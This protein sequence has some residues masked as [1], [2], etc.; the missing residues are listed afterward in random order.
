MFTAISKAIEPAPLPREVITSKRIL[1]SAT[2]MPML[3]RPY[4]GYMY[5]LPVR[6]A[7]TVR[8]LP[9]GENIGLTGW[10]NGFAISA[11]DLQNVPVGTYTIV[12]V[13]VNDVPAG[14]VTPTTF[15]V[16]AGANPDTWIS[17]PVPPQ[18]IPPLPIDR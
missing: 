7:M 9:N 12:M 4:Q 15:N 1:L 18:V 5:Y 11:M 10:T 6:V 16:V 17:V 13:Y 2:G 14:P 8:L 3:P